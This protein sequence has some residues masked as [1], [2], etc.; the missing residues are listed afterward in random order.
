MVP[1]AAVRSRNERWIADEPNGAEILLVRLG[2]TFEVVRCCFR[3]VLE[4]VVDGVHTRF[5]T[6]A[7]K[8]WVSLALKA[9]RTSINQDQVRMEAL[10]VSDLERDGSRRRGDR[11]C[12]MSRFF[13]EARRDGEGSGREVADGVEGRDL[14]VVVQKGVSVGREE[15]VETDEEGKSG[16]SVGGEEVENGGQR[17]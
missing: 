6:R 5:A 7:C 13:D 11:V 10:D 1:G 3:L 9:L 16:H 8:A 15:R 14:K 17:R 4:R 2:V 12:Q